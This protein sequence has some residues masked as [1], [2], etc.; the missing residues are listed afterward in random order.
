MTGMRVSQSAVALIVL[1]TAA[2]PVL[3]V[4]GAQ[5]SPAQVDGGNATAGEVLS[6][7][8]AVHGANLSGKVAERALTVRL[9]RNA[10]VAYRSAV[11]RDRVAAARDR[12][13][14]LERRR[15]AL[16]AARATGEISPRVYRAR[17]T[18]LA[19]EIR[20]V[21]SLVVRTE[22]AA[23]ALPADARREHNIGNETFATILSRTNQTTANRTRLAISRAAGRV[24]MARTNRSYIADYVD[25]DDTE[26]QEA[27]DCADQHIADAMAALER[28][29]EA[30]RNGDYDTA[31]AALEVVQDEMDAAE[32]CLR[33][34]WA[35]ADDG[36][37]GSSTTTESDGSGTPT[38][39]GSFKTYNRT[40]S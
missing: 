30:S 21:E 37:D 34:A 40:K 16:V 33:D 12:L 6:G 8:I 23:S 39:P 17:R 1:L 28:A 20:T 25:E 7:G 38:Y 2:V 11:I 18:R 19:A 4:A 27:L 5:G 13:A 29:R 22:R 10:S 35:A 36:G 26:A 31:Q 15:E 32:R 14:T 3:P 9:E 24:E